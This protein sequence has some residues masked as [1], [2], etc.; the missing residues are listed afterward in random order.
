MQDIVVGSKNV[1]DVTKPSEIVQLL[2]ND[3]QLSTLKTSKPSDLSPNY[4]LD[5]ST[6]PAQDLWNDEEDNFFGH[7]APLAPPSAL[8]GDENGTPVPTNTRGKKR[9]IGG[10]NGARARK[11]AGKKK[12]SNAL[13]SLS[14]AA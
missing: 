8:E 6:T 7:T 5:G 13:E 14:T 3:Q 2:L 11:P 10:H 9:K 12:G 4:L 1:T